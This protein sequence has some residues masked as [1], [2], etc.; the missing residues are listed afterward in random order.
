LIEEAV[1]RGGSAGARNHRCDDREGALTVVLGN[2]LR[3]EIGEGF[4]P[5]T[6]ARVLEVLG[7]VG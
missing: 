2:A 1:P 5:T 3:L 7:R 4:N 6:L